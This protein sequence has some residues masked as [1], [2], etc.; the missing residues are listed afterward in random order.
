[1]KPRTDTP[2]ATSRKRPMHTPLQDVIHP[3]FYRWHER[4]YPTETSL[5]G[6]D[7]TRREMRNAYEAGYRAARRDK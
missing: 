5:V 3:K 2:R 6:G 1:M 7:Y 4:N